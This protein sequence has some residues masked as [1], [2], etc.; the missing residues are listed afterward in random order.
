MTN[1]DNWW[2]SVLNF[3][4]SEVGE[5]GWFD[6]N[7]ALDAQI[8]IRFEVLHQHLSTS[9]LDHLEASPQIYLAA[10]VVLDQFSRNMFRGTPRAFAADP[11]ALAL[12]QRA[13]NAGFDQR[14][15]T[16]ER[17]FMYLPFEHSETLAM[18]VRSLQL[19]ADLG[20][21]NQISYAQ[22]HHDIIARFGR[23]P[24]RNASLGRT[25]TSEE[26]EFLK[27]HAGF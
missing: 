3:W 8:R 6:K 26:L 27:Q 16:R 4:F 18:Q 2:A 10:V 25:S 17:L 9:E 20:D 12:A 1:T 22:Q 19:F 14:L 13:L 24:H 15:L 21:A 5:P 11:L 23:F 7:P